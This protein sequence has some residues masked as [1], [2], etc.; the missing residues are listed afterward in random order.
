MPSPYIKAKS[1]V[2]LNAVPALARLAELTNELLRDALKQ[3]LTSEQQKNLLTNCV[4]AMKGAGIT[5]G[6]ILAEVHSAFPQAE[7]VHVQ[8]PTP[9]PKE[10]VLPTPGFLKR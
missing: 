8:V 10:T 3:P 1:A 7:P 2:H 5:S 4:A 9:A 6:E